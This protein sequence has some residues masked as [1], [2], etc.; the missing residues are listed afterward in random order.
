MTTSAGKHDPYAAL[1]IKEFRFFVFARFI[2]TIGIQMQSLIVGWQV[3]EMTK[4]AFSLGLIG[5]SEAIPYISIALFAGHF[6]DIINRKKIHPSHNE[7]L[8]SLR[9]NIIFVYFQPA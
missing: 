4:D 8:P 2:S 7:P 3:Y 5:L 6:A 9:Y 1:R